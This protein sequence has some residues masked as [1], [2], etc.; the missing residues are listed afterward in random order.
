MTFDWVWYSVW[1]VIAL[2]VI[3]DVL[4]SLLRDPN[5]GDGGGDLWP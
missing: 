4:I 2:L 3:V 1:S 5:R